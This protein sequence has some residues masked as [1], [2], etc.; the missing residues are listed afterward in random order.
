MLIY[1][2]FH[3]GNMTLKWVNI[4]SML[5]HLAAENSSGRRAIKTTSFNT[6]LSRGNISKI[7]KSRRWGP[8]NPIKLSVWNNVPMFCLTDYKTSPSLTSPVTDIWSNGR[9]PKLILLSLTKNRSLQVMISTYIILL[10]FGKKTS[11]SQVLN[12]TQSIDR[13]SLNL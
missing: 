11:S 3:G 9:L 8:T 7:R 6:D 2:K 4:K 12:L 10:L 13:N 5:R 1:L